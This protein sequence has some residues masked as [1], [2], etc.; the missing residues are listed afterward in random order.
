[1]GEHFEN[2]SKGIPF[3]ISYSVNE[4]VYRGNTYLQLRVKD[5]QYP[6]DSYDEIDLKGE[7]PKANSAG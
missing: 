1:M 7:N 5:I 3:N 4:N 2:I 6:N